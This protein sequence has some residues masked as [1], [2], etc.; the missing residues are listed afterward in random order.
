MLAYHLDPVDYSGNSDIWVTQPGSGSPL[1]LTADYPGADKYPSYSPDGRQIA[2]WSSRDGG[3]YFVMPALGGPPRKVLAGSRFGFSRPEWSSDGKR[4]ACVVREKGLRT[5]VV[6]TLETGESRRVSLPGRE[7]NRWD[8][9]WSHDQLYFA[10]VDAKS[11]TSQVGRILVLGLQDG[12]T[13]EVTDGRTAVWSPNWSSDGRDLYYISNRGGS[14][15]LWRQRIEDGKP[16]SDPQPLTIGVGI[17]SAAFSPDGRK[18][19]YSK[20][21]VVANVWRVPILQ[22]RPANWSDARQLT[23]D[24][25]YIE[26]V[27]VSRDGERLV[28]SSDRAGNPDLWLL[29]AE[30]GPMQQ[31]TT[32]LTPD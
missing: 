16:V 21:R 14:M 8:L 28:V 26:M 6:V 17:T 3:G 15:D 10:Y 29:P 1:N 5:A 19:A 13:T 9:A 24:E 11:D 25:A 7:T 30:G 4:L 22:D 18:L 31:L 32:D 20:G 12:K 23:F 2:F 27:D